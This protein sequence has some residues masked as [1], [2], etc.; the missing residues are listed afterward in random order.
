M[1]DRSHLEPLPGSIDEVLEIA[2][3]LGGEAY[4]GTSASEGRF[5]ALA[6]ESQ[7]IHLATHAFLDDDD[8]L[9]SKLVFSEDLLE[10]EDGLLNVY[11][12]YN[13]DLNAGMAVLSSCNTGLGEMKGGEGIMSLARAFYYAGVPNIVMTLWTVIDRQ[14]NKLML[15]FYK[16][17]SKGRKAEISLRNAKL[18]F[19]ESAPPRYQHPRYW[20]G[21]ILVGNPENLFFPRL[22]RQLLFAAG[23]FVILLTG[24]MMAKKRLKKRD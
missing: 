10:G 8:P 5:K 4:T 11:E 22:Y 2:K 14:S 16:Q 20:A 13:M 15:G 3:L 6:G 17:L 23:I 18:E 24:I 9:M 12:L 19:L 1:I 7:I 21:Y